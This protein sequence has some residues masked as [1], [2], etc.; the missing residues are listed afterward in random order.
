MCNTLYPLPVKSPDGL[1]L[2]HRQ[3][4]LSLHPLS[5]LTLLRSLLLPRCTTT[6]RSATTCNFNRNTIHQHPPCCRSCIAHSYPKA[7][8]RGSH[9]V[10]RPFSHDI[11]MRSASVPRLVVRN[12][13]TR[14]HDTVHSRLCAPRRG[15][16]SQC[17][18]SLT[19]VRVRSWRP[20][21]PHQRFQLRPCLLLDAGPS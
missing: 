16:A 4:H 13:H 19:I 17:K 11:R 1:T 5:N 2:Q 12:V 14:T 10:G 20:S 9:S 6:W 3:Q 7:D 15:A 18:L 21:I 8:L